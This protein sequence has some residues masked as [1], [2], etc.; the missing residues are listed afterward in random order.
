MTLPPESKAAPQ[1]APLDT[2]VLLSIVV[3][4]FNEADNIPLLQTRLSAT[5]QRI[6]PDAWELI[7]IDDG[8]RDATWPVIE[9]LSAEDSRVRGV[10]LSRN[11]G[12]QAALSAGLDASI[13]DA[14]TLLPPLASD[15]ASATINSLVYLGHNRK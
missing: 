6:V 8:S 12:H 14:S 9:R 10:R 15:A 13:G 3:P 2:G 11:F 1:M 5:L 7:L 4:A